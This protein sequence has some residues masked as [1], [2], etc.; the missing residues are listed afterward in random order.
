MMK[1]TD[2]KKHLA[3]QSKED[4]IKEI[5]DLYRKNAFVKDY[6]ETKYSSDSGASI[7][8]KHKEIIDHEFFP[9]N[10][11]GKARLSVAKKAI[12][13]FKKLSSDAESIAELMVYYVETGVKFTE[14]YG[15]INEAFYLSMESMYQRATKFI[16][17][18]GLEH[19]FQQRC[20]KIVDDTVNMGWGFHDELA[21]IY[22]DQ[23]GE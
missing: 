1:V 3:Q 6:Y 17:D 5:A 22:Y 23:F 4:L 12:T 11:F 10:G 19:P 2:L 9:V 20:Q 8:E 7:L 16:I 13:E 18:K 15:D 21:D 14:C